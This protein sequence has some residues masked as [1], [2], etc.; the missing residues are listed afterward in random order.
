MVEK[1]RQRPSSPERPWSLVLY[2]D[3]VTP[4]AVLATQPTRKSQSIYYSFLELGHVALAREESWLCAMV[5]RSSSVA[6][7]DGGMGQVVGAILKLLFP[8]QGADLHLTGLMLYDEGGQGFRLHARLATFV[9]DG[10]AHKDIWKCKGD[11][12]TRMCMCCL[13]V[14]AGSDLR[15]IRCNR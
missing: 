14:A 1:H 13:V 9:Q 8:A 11:S 5:H 12:G 7:A 15:D 6:T 10:A 2:S 4:R 3:E